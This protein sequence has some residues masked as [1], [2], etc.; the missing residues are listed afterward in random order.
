MSSIENKTLKERGGL[1]GE[2]AATQKEYGSAA[3]DGWRMNTQGHSIVLK[4]LSSC[5]A[6]ASSTSYTLHGIKD[7]KGK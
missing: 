1:W 2:L 4:K 3:P 6:M 5:K 7:G